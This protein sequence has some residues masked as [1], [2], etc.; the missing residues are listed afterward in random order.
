MTTKRTEKKSAS[1]LDGYLQLSKSIITRPVPHTDKALGVSMALALFGALQTVEAQ[2]VYSG[3]QNVACTLVGNTNRCYANIDL[4]GGMDFEIHRNHAVGNQFIQADEVGGGGFA[5]NGFNAQVAGAYQYPYALV[6][7]AVIGA[8][9]PWG[10][11]AGQSNSLSE[12]NNAYPND[13]WTALP[14]GTTRFLG[15]RGTHA[16]QTKYGW[17]RLTK[18]G[19]GN[20][21]IVDWAYNNT[22]NQQI[23]AGLFV[24]SAA[25]VSISGQVLTPDGRGLRNAIVVLTDSGGQTR[26]ARTSTFG[27][28]RLDDIAVGQTAVMSVRSKVFQFDPHIINVNDNLE[29]INFTARK[30]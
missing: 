8:A 28:Y 24:P 13:K 4:A 1:K 19:F 30:E 7:G 14:N 6:T 21:T 27:Y 18:N 15:I 25:N 22:P 26:T 10:F 29:S 17:I 20:F 16:G 12:I 11:A 23:L 3:P 9:G 2:I 5:I